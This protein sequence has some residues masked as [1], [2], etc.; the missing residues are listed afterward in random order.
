MGTSGSMTLEEQLR[1]MAGT[2]SERQLIERWLRPVPSQTSGQ[3]AST[4][5]MI[6]SDP[7]PEA[8]HVDSPSSAPAQPSP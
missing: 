8:A 2:S 5:A 4:R 6:G 1:S 7:A 3:V